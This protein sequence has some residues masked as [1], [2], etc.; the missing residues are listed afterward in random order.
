MRPLILLL[1]VGC[2][3]ETEPRRDRQA[4]T[5]PTV[6][7]EPVVIPPSLELGDG[8]QT[9]I[10]C[11]PGQET[12]LEYGSQ[13]GFHFW[14]SGQVSH[15]TE[16][17]WVSSEVRRVSDDALVGVAEPL[18]VLLADFDVPRQSGWFAGDESR[19][20]DIPTGCS[21]DGELVEVCAMAES[22]ERDRFVQTCLQMTA[23]VDPEDA[24]RCE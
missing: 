22:L 5:D 15:L 1:A 4:P 7:T 12:F 16:A 18:P 11:E 13:G 14:V 21:L 6:P 20:P 10:P 3:T 19:V 23:R 9:H 8:A 17:V 24:W 2:A